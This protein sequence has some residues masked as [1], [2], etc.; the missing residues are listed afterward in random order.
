MN[1]HNKLYYASQLTYAAVALQRNNIHQFEG[2]AGC[3]V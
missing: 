2:T 1:L 3:D